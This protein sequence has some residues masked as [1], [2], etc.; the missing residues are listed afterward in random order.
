M[1]EKYLKQDAFEKLIQELKADNDEDSNSELMV[2][3]GVFLEQTHLQN[4]NEKM[5]C[6]EEFR[7]LFWELGS[8]RQSA[9]GFL[10]TTS[11]ADRN[12]L[13]D[14]SHG[15]LDSLL[16]N[17]DQMRWLENISPVLHEAY[18]GLKSS[19]EHLLQV[20]IG[21]TFEVYQNCF[22]EGPQWWQEVS[23]DID[24]VSHDRYIVSG[25]NEVRL[26]PKND[27]GRTREEKLCSKTPYNENNMC[28]TFF[29]L[30]VHG[31]FLVSLLMQV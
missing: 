31:Y 28:G 19:E 9:I 12:Y 4:D 5:N 27:T 3:L 15:K 25:R 18:C 29:L 14:L 6:R 24:P 16:N 7:G 23:E 13:V 10:Q 17:P 2:C 8:P 22:H 20:L 1:P 21:Y 26:L 30:C 11:R